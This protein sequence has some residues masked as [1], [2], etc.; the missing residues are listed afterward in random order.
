M[1][2]KIA[3]QMV[4]WNNLCFRSSEHLIRRAPYKKDL[5]SCPYIV[6]FVDWRQRVFRVLKLSF[7]LYKVTHLFM[8]K[9]SGTWC[10]YVQ[11]SGVFS[12]VLWFFICVFLQWV[13]KASGSLSAALQFQVWKPVTLQANQTSLTFQIFAYLK[14]HS[15]SSILLKF[16]VYNIW[17]K[18]WLGNNA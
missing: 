5:G 16:C 6:K 7:H 13:K 4:I 11:P 1:R 15:D 10:S 2:A 3:H 17:V 14:Q 18:S 9:K 12:F 8:L